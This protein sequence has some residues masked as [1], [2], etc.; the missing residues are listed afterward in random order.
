MYAY[1]SDISNYKQCS[2]CKR[3]YPKNQIETLWCNRQKKNYCVYCL[4][5]VP[6]D[7]IPIRYVANGHRAIKIYS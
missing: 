2:N 7:D 6:I 5:D 4:E 3:L 1:N